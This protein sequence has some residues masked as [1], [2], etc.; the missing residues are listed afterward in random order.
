MVP[1]P[2]PRLSTVTVWRKASDSFCATTRAIAST[3]PPAGY[4][5]TSVMA[6]VGKSAAQAVDISEDATV[7]AMVIAAAVTRLRRDNSSMRWP[8]LHATATRPSQNT[9]M[10]WRCGRQIHGWI[11]VMGQGLLNTGA[12][13]RGRFRRHTA[14]AVRRHTARPD[15]KKNHAKWNGPP[16]LKLR[17]QPA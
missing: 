1:P 9:S 10:L 12:V 13:R 5:T 16:F 8:L 7:D 15:R 3:P 4:G 11:I 6:R 2:P 17:Y 14:D